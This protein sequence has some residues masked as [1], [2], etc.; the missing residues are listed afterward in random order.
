MIEASVSI[1]RQSGLAADEDSEAEKRNRHEYWLGFR[2]TRSYLY[3]LYVRGKVGGIVSDLLSELW[4][5][6]ICIKD[7][8]VFPSQ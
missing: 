4:S 7:R 8:R 6:R 1:V 5:R 2:V 3:D